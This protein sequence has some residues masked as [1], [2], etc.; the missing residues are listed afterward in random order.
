QASPAAGALEAFPVT[1]SDAA[2]AARITD[3]QPKK[4]TGRP[5]LTEAAIGRAAVALVPSPVPSVAA[6]GAARITASQPKKSTGRPELTEAAIVVAGGRGTSG[7]FAPVEE[8]A[9]SL[10]AAG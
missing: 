3:S 1:L 5:E 2:R 7:D 8:F 9:D 6:P 10:G 4:P